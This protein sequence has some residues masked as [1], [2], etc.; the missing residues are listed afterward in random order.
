MSASCFEN[1]LVG[2]YTD[3]RGGR[4]WPSAA[5]WGAWIA[6]TWRATAPCDDLVVELDSFS[7]ILESAVDR[8]RLRSGRGPGAARAP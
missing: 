3:A 1:A 7:G 2:C 6:E 5:S 8:E 4:R